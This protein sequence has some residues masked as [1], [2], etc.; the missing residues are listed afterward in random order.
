[1]RRG[2]EV[3]V[4]RSGSIYEVERISLPFRGLRKRV[5]EH[6]RADSGSCDT[7]QSASRLRTDQSDGYS[8]TRPFQRCKMHR[9]RRRC[10]RGGET[11]AL[12]VLLFGTIS[13][14]VRPVDGDWGPR[15]SP[16]I[17]G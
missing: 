14:C 10:Y 17:C 13:V 5:P 9:G 16:M 1:M 7:T 12:P 3:I 4:M 15:A 11:C 2:L 8:C 6:N